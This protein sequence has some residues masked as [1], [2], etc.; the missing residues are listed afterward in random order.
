MEALPLGNGRIGAMCFGRPGADLIKLNDDRGWSGSPANELQ[1]GFPDAASAQADVGAARAAVAAGDYAAADEPLRRI[2]QKYT[3]SYLPFSDLHLTITAANGTTDATDYRRELRLKDAV[4]E[5]SYLLDGHRVTQSSYISAPAGVMVI[6]ISAEHPDGVDLTLALSTELL[7]LDRLAVGGRLGLIAQLP[8]NSAPGHESDLEQTKYDR[9]PGAAVIGGT[10][11]R[12][13]HDGEERDGVGAVG[14]SGIHR[15]TIILT[16]ATTFTALGM[17]PLHT[18][19]APAAEA[20]R[21]LDAADELGSDR[22][23]AEHLA[24]Y[25][26]LYFRSELHFDRRDDA[27]MHDDLPTSERLALASASPIGALGSDPGLAATLFNFGRYLLIASSRAGTLPTNLQGI[28]N[29]LVQPPWSSNYT[30]NINTQMN[31][32]PVEVANLAELHEPLFDLVDALA[33]RGRETA[34]RIYGLPGWVAHHNTDPWG[35]STPVGMGRADNAWAYWPM[36]GP[37][38]VSHL[39]QHLQF[40]ADD[41]FARDRAWPVAASAAAFMLGWLKTDADGTLGTPVSTSPENHFV[42]EAGERASVAASTTMDISLIRELFEFVVS[43]ADRLKIDSSTA[44]A[45]AAALPRLRA[46]QIGVDGRLLEYPHGLPDWEPHHRHVSHLYG[47]YPGAERW[48]ADLLA[49][50]TTSLDVRGGDSTGWSLAWKTCLRARL[51]QPDVAGELLAL[52]FREPQDGI[53]EWA[54]ALYPNLFQSNPPFQIDANLGYIAAIAECLL[55][56]H[57]GVIELLPALP[58]ALDRGSVRGLVARPGVEV[59]LEWKDGKLVAAS[60]TSRR[61]RTVTVEYD[62][63][64]AA[65]DLTAGARAR[66]DI[67]L[68]APLESLPA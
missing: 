29:D 23:L 48:D 16:T 20:Q 2:Q 62:G 65:V 27:A 15:A 13:H 68:L 56:S 46:P 7:E 10:F 3:Q 52:F 31:Y 24:D 38:L 17:P 1:D 51:H 14:A 50:A 45:C 53:A 11:L 44:R 66:L 35:F 4:H 57:R 59:D 40:G 64:S 6:E 25:R 43:L 58:P 28:W 12:L 42:T 47:L 61:S 49:A 36:S 67:T 63:R 39:S 34:S 30:I 9:T 37:W 21:R 32:W 19:D 18:L 22:L 8:S 60:L 33:L 55:Q 41:E 26:G 54:G 5:H